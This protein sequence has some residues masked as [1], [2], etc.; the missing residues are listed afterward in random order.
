MIYFKL[1]VV[2]IVGILVAIVYSTMSFANAGNSYCTKEAVSGDTSTFCF[3]TAGNDRIGANGLDNVIVGLAGDDQIDGAGGSNGIC[4]GPGND[5]INGGDG[6]DEIAGDGVSA[7]AICT[8][9][10]GSD[11]ISGG[12]GNDNIWHGDEVGPLSTPSDGHKDFI[13]CGPGEDT[14]FI[15]TSVDHDVASNC[16]H[17]HAG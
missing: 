8:D 9:G 3:G 6:K 12:P 13:D 4:G 16:E 11:Q 17:V 7:G 2:G 1:T 14:I 15:N 10:N 5:I